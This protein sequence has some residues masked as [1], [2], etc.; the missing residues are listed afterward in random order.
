[1]NEDGD[2]NLKATSIRID[3]ELWRKFERACEDNYTNRTSKL[4]QFIHAYVHKWEMQQ[5]VLSDEAE[6]RIASQIE[7]IV[8]KKS[9]L[10]L[11]DILDNMLEQGMTREEIEKAADPDSIVDMLGE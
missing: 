1:M 2:V 9:I 7:D 6:N 5:G 10:I 4:N 11:Q 3:V 8:K